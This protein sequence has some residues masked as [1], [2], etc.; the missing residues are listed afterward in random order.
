[1]NIASG[2]NTSVFQSG[3]NK[4]IRPALEPFGLR[5]TLSYATKSNSNAM[6]APAVDGVALVE[7]AATSKQRAYGVN[8]HRKKPMDGP[9]LPFRNASYAW[10][11]TANATTNSKG[12][13]GL[14][15]K[16][17]RD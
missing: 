13:E 4:S 1:M 10:S 6:V 17:W 11:A 3:A 2:E 16:A 8:G 15:W 12:N 5:N 14:P 7:N 9:P